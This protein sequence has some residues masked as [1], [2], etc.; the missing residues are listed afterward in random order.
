VDSIYQQLRNPALKMT[1]VAAALGLPRTHFEAALIEKLQHYVGKRVE[2]VGGQLGVKPSNA[3]DYA[4]R[5]VWTLLGARRRDARLREF[6]AFGVSRKTVPIGPRRTALEHT[7]VVP[8]RIDELIDETWEDS[9]LREALGRVLFVPLR[10]SK[11]GDY[12][13]DRV[14]GPPFFWTPSET[15]WN[16]LRAEWQMFHD[17]IATGGIRDLPTAKSTQMLHVRTKGRDSR[18]IDPSQRFASVPRRA[19]WLNAKFV[20]DLI[21]RST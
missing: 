16:L 21:R 3:K 14:I 10:V 8:F 17:K 6:D 20:A 19:F 9:L 2:T 5:I 12:Q 7:Y 11:R 15:E 1:S 18:D 4:A 13:G